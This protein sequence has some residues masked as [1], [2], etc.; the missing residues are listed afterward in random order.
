MKALAN[1][2]HNQDSF[3]VFESNQL[4]K[5]YFLATI[6]PRGCAS[7]DV[8]LQKK[9]KNNILITL[10]ITSDQAAV[11]IPNAPFGGFW[12]EKSLNA[13][14]FEVFL[15]SIEQELTGRGIQSLTIT[16][17]PKAYESQ[18]DLIN[19]LLFK[20]GWELKSMVSHQFFCGRKKIKKF[21]EKESPKLV[22]KLKAGKL[23]SSHSQISNFEFLNKIKLWYNQKG[24]KFNVNEDLLVHQVSSFPD[25]YFLIKLELKEQT[26]GYALA[27][28]LTTNSIYYFLSAIDPYIK[29]ASGGDFLL[30]ELFLLAKEEK[31]DFIDLGSSDLKE[32]A[33]YS[34]IF[35]KSRFSNEISNKMTWHKEF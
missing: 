27:V 13:Q 26:V 20:S 35:F 7:F 23:T 5:D 6:P 11:S 19:Y 18:S 21:L 2:I 29:I 3:Q 16:Q 33:N 9:G 4:A 8:A 10:V 24:F 25:R 30:H 34:L 1:D 22:A 31:V 12:S 14:S 15:N 28:K 17:A 32:N